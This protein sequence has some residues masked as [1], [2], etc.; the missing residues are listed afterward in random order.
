[1][2]KILTSALVLSMAIFQ[3]SCQYP[4]ATSGLPDPKK[5]L[6]INVDLTESYGKL[7]VGYSLSDVSS[8][9]GFNYTPKPLLTNAHIKDGQGNKAFFM[10]DG[11]LDTL[12]HARVGETYQLFLEVAGV[13]YESIV[14]T[15][16][17]CPSIDTIKPVFT[18]EINRAPKDL[19]YDGFDVYVNLQDT[20]GEENFYQWDWVHYER[21][22]ACDKEYNRTFRADVLIPCVPFNCWTIAY[23]RKTIVQSDELRDGQ[24]I[25]QKIA[26]VPFIKPPQKYYIRI[27]QRSVT[28]KV[29]AYLQSIEAQTQNIGTLYDLPAQTVFSPNIKNINDPS[30]QILGVFNVFSSKFKVVYIDRSGNYFGSDARLVVDPTPFTSDPFATAPCTENL[31]RT[32]QKPIGWV[33]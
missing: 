11:R 28:P 12:F 32:Q 20:P 16:R 27:E 9:G 24:E 8:S 31:F 2:K 15:M 26:R 22:F 4:V 21:T 7:D 18:R 33:D 6:I 3:F 5:F 13:P 14:E 30:E 25:S 29:F 10:P 23:N 17:S 19:F 1:M